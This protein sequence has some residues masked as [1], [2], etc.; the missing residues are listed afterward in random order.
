M[1]HAVHEDFAMSQR[2]DPYRAGP[3][4]DPLEAVPAKFNAESDPHL[5]G[6]HD[7]ARRA[8]DEMALYMVA[9]CRG[10]GVEVPAGVEMPGEW[11]G[12]V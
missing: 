11:R 2:P 10:A 6:L 4:L 1:Y 7:N 9:R 8:F 12:N 3:S 5:I